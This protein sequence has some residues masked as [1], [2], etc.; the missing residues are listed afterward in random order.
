MPDPT[1]PA[2]VRFDE[3]LCYEKR[4]IRAAVAFATV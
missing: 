3:D 2:L 4:V 1:T